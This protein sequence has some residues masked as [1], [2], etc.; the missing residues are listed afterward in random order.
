M[1][2]RKTTVWEKHI[3]TRKMEGEVK[4]L[5][6]PSKKMHHTH[7]HMHDIVTRGTIVCTE[8]ESQEPNP[9]TPQ[10]IGNWR[11]LLW[12]GRTKKRTPGAPVA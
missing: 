4:A 1:D 6:S 11:W 5:S 10:N 9:T 7:T 3:H 2:K 12:L 8:K